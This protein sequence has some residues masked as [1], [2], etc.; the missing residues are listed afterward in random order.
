[1]PGNR[2]HGVVIVGGGTAGWMAAA[3]LAR[4]LGTRFG[5][6]SV[7]ESPEIGIIGVGEATIPPI[8]LFNT[9]LGVDEGEFLSRTRG[10]IKLGIEFRDW[11]RQGHSYFHPFGVHGTSLQQVTIH[12][13]WLAARQSGAVGSF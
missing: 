5:P 10:T 12:Q 7:I 9:A 2:V 1:M 13:D 6:I 8:R 3:I 11:S 4:R